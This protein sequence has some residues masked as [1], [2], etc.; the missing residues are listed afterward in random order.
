MFKFLEKRGIKVISLEENNNLS[1][2]TIDEVKKLINEKQIKYIYSSSKDTNETVKSQ[3]KTYKIE[4]INLNTM[5][6][7]DGGITNSNDN[8]LTI[9][10]NNINELKKELYK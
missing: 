10:T 2:N 4:K 3:N 8:Y 5:H 1:N 7:I 9:M 6:S